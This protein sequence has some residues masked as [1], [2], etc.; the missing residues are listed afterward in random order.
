MLTLRPL[1]YFHCECP[2]D[3]YVTF[4]LTVLTSPYPARPQTSTPTHRRTREERWYYVVK[5]SQA[6]KSA[7]GDGI[8]EGVVR[9]NEYETQGKRFTG[10]EF[11]ETVKN[12]ETGVVGRVQVGEDGFFQGCFFLGMVGEN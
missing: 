6:E 5:A 8:I 12:F 1:R 7:T 2:R 3:H 11:D 10:Y 9:N 4:I